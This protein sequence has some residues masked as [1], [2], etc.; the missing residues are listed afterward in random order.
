VIREREID[1]VWLNAMIHPHGA[2]AAWLEGVPA[3][4]QLIDEFPP[5]FL[6]RMVMPFVVRTAACVMTT[7]MH[8]ARVHPGAAALGDRLIPFFPP[9]DVNR[10]RADPA[11]R[12]E[13][14]AELGLGPDD[15]VIGN[16]ANLA[17]YKDHV[18]FVRAAA[19]LRLEFP[20]ARFVIMVFTFTQ[21]PKYAASVRYE[22]QRLGLEIGKDIIFR[23]PGGHVA[24]L[25]QA[26]DIFWLTSRSNEGAPTVLCEAMSL[27]LPIVATRIASVPEMIDDGRNGFVVP[28]GNPQAVA[29]ATAKIIRDRA[30]R[31]TISAHARKT[32]IEKFNVTVCAELHA[33]A[34]RMAVREPAVP[35]KIVPMSA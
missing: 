23:D 1:A 28:I 24:E 15:L 30:L 32:A 20:R 21:Y 7:G 25:A 22:A 4:W 26:F 17:P 18:T 5:M 34:L 9:V 27:G 19:A 29:S 31:E 8:T 13:A 35:K 10:F 6:R 12:N 3:M 2:I 33:R 16:V 14:R 11:V